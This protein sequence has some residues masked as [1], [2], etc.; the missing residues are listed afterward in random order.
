M[1]LIEQRLPLAHSSDFS[2]LL[3]FF[4]LLNTEVKEE[5]TVSVQSEVL[6]GNTAVRLTEFDVTGFVSVHPVGV[7]AVDVGPHRHGGVW[8]NHDVS[9][10]QQQA[11]WAQR[12][13]PLL[14]LFNSHRDQNIE[15]Y[16][17]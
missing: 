15:S 10:E 13:A 16:F 1:E 17:N 6:E 3:A 9:A 4:M 11:V 14:N 7:A 8:K 12:S 5:N 2:S